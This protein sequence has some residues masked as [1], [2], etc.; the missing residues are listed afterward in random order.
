MHFDSNIFS[1]T[2]H[3]MNGA[4]GKIAMEFGI[5]EYV[6][7]YNWKENAQATRAV[8]SSASIHLALLRS[9]DGKLTFWRCIISLF[10]SVRKSRVVLIIGWVMCWCRRWRIDTFDGLEEFFLRISPI[11][12]IP[13]RSWIDC[14]MMVAHILGKLAKSATA[15]AIRKIGAR[16]AASEMHFRYLLPSV[17]NELCFVHVVHV[18]YLRWHVN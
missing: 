5:N 18:E 6:G 10:C 12:Y 17:R 3:M 14:V 11:S 2:K 1:I 7:I 16:L 8:A 13:H 9:L 4:N 15:H